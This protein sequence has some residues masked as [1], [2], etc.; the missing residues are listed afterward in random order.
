ML[1]DTNKTFHSLPTTPYSCV[2]YVS[3]F[4]FLIGNDEY[5][6]EPKPKEDSSLANAKYSVE[7]IPMFVEARKKWLAAQETK[8]MLTLN[9]HHETNET[10]VLASSISPVNMLYMN[11]VQQS[12]RDHIPSGRRLSIEY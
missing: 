5:F 9:E 6:I 7:H 10:E 11:V 2:S 12:T 4:I 8:R 1:L 3:I